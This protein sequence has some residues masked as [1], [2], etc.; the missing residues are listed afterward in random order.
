MKKID[1]WIHSE[2]TYFILKW[3]KKHKYQMHKYNLLMSVK[4]KMM[5]LVGFIL[6]FWISKSLIAHDWGF[7]MVMSLGFVVIVFE[8]LE[9]PMLKD[10]ID[11]YDVIFLN[12]KNP[13]VYLAIKEYS[14]KAFE[15][16]RTWRESFVAFDFGF[17]LFCLFLFIETG[18]GLLTLSIFVPINLFNLYRLYNHTIF[19][20]DE[21]PDKPKEV[22]TK[23]TEVAMAAWQRLIRTEPSPA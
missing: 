11:W 7:V 2:L 13:A 4:I 15:D 8:F 12:R 3:I 23:L 1:D 18:A 16:N 14:E 20:M 21:P 22:K 19:D 10:T 17:I 6:G 9:M 5:Y